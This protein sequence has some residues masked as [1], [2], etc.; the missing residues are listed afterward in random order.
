MTCLLVPPLGLAHTYVAYKNKR[1]QKARKQLIFSSIG[2]GWVLLATILLLIFRPFTK[3]P[4]KVTHNKEGQEWAFVVNNI[5]FT[6]K[7]VEG[8]SFNMGGTDDEADADEKPIHRVTLDSYY[9]GEVEVTRGLWYAVM[10]NKRIWGHGRNMP[11]ELG[12]ELKSAYDFISKLNR[13]TGLHFRLPTEAEWE[14]AARGGRKSGNF[15]YAGSQS[16][17]D[18]AWF[19][20]NSDKTSHRVKEKAPNEL[21]LYD[22][23][24]SLW[25]LCSDLYGPYDA[26]PQTNPT[27]QPSGS[28]LVVRGGSWRNRSYYCRVSYRNSVDEENDNAYH[29]GLRLVLKDETHPE[30]LAKHGEATENY[31]ET[32]N[33]N[34]K[35][36]A[37]EMKLV[38]GA[39]FDMGGYSDAD[40]ATPEHKV[41][42]DGYYIGETEVTQA[43]WEAVMGTTVEQ[44]MMKSKDSEEGL[45][46]VG[47]DYPMYYLNW[48]DCQEFIEKLDSITGKGFRLPTEA[49]WE[50][51][52]RG[53]RT[54]GYKYAGS[55][56]LDEVSWYQDNSGGTS[57]PVKQLQ[58]NAIGVYDMNGN[59]WEW[60]S[61]W[62]D[63]Y[64]KEPKYNPTGPSEGNFRVVR[65]ASWNSTEE[66]HSVSARNNHMPDFR[67]IRFGFRLAL[68]LD[69]EFKS[70]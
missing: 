68:P 63:S 53:G 2:V 20:D 59:V 4:T 19:R 66:R 52:A 28:E 51:A 62:Y 33:F 1:K 24:G 43:L 54:K 10:D 29:L 15:L 58:H 34:V 25:E 11:M 23:S 41:T 67:H 32:L 26:T 17:Y 70:K 9:I 36:V 38:R 44:M 6:M 65:G 39:T 69:D 56:R 3:V 7:Y 31:K 55:N 16:I 35:D 40:D 18:V 49:E 61:D 57:H 21:G 60:C 46:G 64:T 42:L 30:A 14:Y 37:F 8:G 12:D 45:K 50:F 47:P 5:P 13:L 22:M 27:G 48:Y